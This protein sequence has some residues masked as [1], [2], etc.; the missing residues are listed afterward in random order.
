MPVK[1]ET[2]VVE[3]KK[4]IGVYAD[5]F[6]S[7]TGGKIISTEYW[8]DPVKGEVVFRLLVEAKEDNRPG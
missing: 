3:L 1:F 4:I 8:I 6:K 5:G 7:P 2:A